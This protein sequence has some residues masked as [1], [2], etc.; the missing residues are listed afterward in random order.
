MSFLASSDGTSASMKIIQT[1]QRVGDGVLATLHVL[2]LHRFIEK[3]GEPAEDTHRCVWL[4]RQQ[5]LQRKMVSL[6]PKRTRQPIYSKMFERADNREAHALKSE[7]V[8]LRNERFNSKQR[9]SV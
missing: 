2:D 8:S 1:I 7:V 6:Q 9:F 4:I 3:R 5:P